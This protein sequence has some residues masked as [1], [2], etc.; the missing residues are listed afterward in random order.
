MAVAVAVGAVVVVVV[1]AEGKSDAKPVWHRALAVTD[2]AGCR[3]DDRR[4][5]GGG[6]DFR[7]Y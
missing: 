1:V 2:R 3:F 5:G 6:R 7:R 4:G